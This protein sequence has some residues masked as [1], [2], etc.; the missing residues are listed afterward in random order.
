MTRGEPVAPNGSNFQFILDGQQRLTSLYAIFT[1][2]APPF[3]EGEKLFFNLYFNVLDETFEFW[4][5]VKMKGNPAWVPVTDFLETGL[6]TFTDGLAALPNDVHDLYQKN[7]ARFIRLDSIRNYS[8]ELEVIPGGGQEMAVQEVVEI[9]NLVNSK[10][11][12]LSKADLALAYICGTWPEA[13]ETFRQFGRELKASGF[14]FGF[15]LLVRCLAS[16]AVG[17][18]LLE[19]AFYKTPIEVIQNA[20]QTTRKA[21][22]YVLDILRGE[23]QIDGAS[24][25][26]TPYVIV[27][28]VSYVA[29]QGGAFL[30]DKE[31]RRF[32]RWLYAAQM[33]QR[34]S[35]STESNLQAD[36]NVLGADD[37]VDALLHNILSV[38]NR[39]TV[40]SKDLEGRGVDSAFYKMT[41]L[42]ARS[43]GAVDWF[44]GLPLA[45]QGPGH[46]AQI[47]DHHV[48][49]AETLYK[50]KYPTRDRDAIRK[51]NDM[52]NRV[53][54]LAHPT[55]HGTDRLPEN[56]LPEVAK[57]FPNALR[58]Q[59]IPEDP[60]L[61][62]LERYED[63]L[64][65]RRKL[66]AK[67]I[68]E[69]MDHLLEA[70]D[71]R[72]L[73]DVHALIDGGEGHTVEFKSTARWDV[74]QQKLT[75]IPGEEVVK[76]VAGF[77]NSEGGRLVIG[78]EDQR[79][80]LGLECDYV[81][82]RQPAR[83]KHELFIVNL[84]AAKM[85]K[86]ICA[87]IRITYHELDGKDVCVVA[88]DKSAMPVYVVDGPQARFYVRIGN[89]TQELNVQEAL[90]YIQQHWG[91]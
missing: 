88:A 80:I 8:Y 78:V 86:H 27:P 90:A 70:Q 15:D 76:T 40:E 84:L 38:T 46:A 50:A 74:Y 5:P 24:R 71:R 33:W 49:P 85:G 83:D 87:Q 62:R 30:T 58:A 52:A 31:K 22:A 2:D 91:K 19:G 26:A 34:Y 73:P 72:P 41:Y 67:A 23:G 14:D 25:L 81:G 43:R 79:Q 10:G 54:L 44:S 29:R 77:M 48:F 68:N 18:V 28:L 65:A 12:P 37:A 21:L 57:K 59:F 47:R 61:W 17:S 11:T 56:Y 69:F 66:I 53:F 42:V 3:Y 64:V 4:Q 89:T 39:I 35:G 82:L 16:V 6:D 75:K 51:V 9:F 7:L 20:W 45:G 1:G 32:L 63:F 55:L 60:D 13:R 36:I